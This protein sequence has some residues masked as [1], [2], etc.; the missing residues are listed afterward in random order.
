MWWSEAYL[1]QSHSIIN[2]KKNERSDKSKIENWGV[3]ETIK[4]QRTM[5]SR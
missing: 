3:T 1:L 2:E 4:N 5:E